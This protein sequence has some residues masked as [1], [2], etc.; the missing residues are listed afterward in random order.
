MLLLN[1]SVRTAESTGWNHPILRESFN[2]S[3]KTVAVDLQALF[4]G[5][6][7]LLLV[8]KIVTTR[9][10]RPEYLPRRLTTP[11]FDNPDIRQCAFLGVLRSILCA[12]IHDNFTLTPFGPSIRLED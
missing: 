5:Y 8:P 12:S 10:L 3:P 11:I 6:L 4:L 7:G 9:R 2:F 1:W